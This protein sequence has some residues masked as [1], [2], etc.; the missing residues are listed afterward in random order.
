M[1]KDCYT[2]RE[3]KLTNLMTVPAQ[4]VLT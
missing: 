1:L 4:L 3:R 2:E